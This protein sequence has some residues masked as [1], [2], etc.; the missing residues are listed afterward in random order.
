MECRRVMSLILSGLIVLGALGRPEIAAAYQ[1]NSGGGDPCSLKWFQPGSVEGPSWSAGTFERRATLHLSCC[2]ENLR[3]TADA[4][5]TP[6]GAPQGDLA[7]AQ[8]DSARASATLAQSAADAAKESAKAAQAGSKSPQADAASAKANKD[9]ATQAATDATT[10][11]TAADSVT[12]LRLPAMACINDDVLRL[13]AAHESQAE[14]QR[15]TFGAETWVSGA[16]AMALIVGGAKAAA[17]TTA[18]WSVVA[19]GPSV[20]EDIGAFGARSQLHYGAARAFGRLGEH[21]G[22]LDRHFT[23]LSKLLPQ[24]GL[25]SAA[26]AK[27]PDALPASADAAPSLLNADLKAVAAYCTDFTAALEQAQAFRD[28]MATARNDLPELYVEDAQSLEGI[29]HKLA[30]GMQAPPSQALQIVLSAPLD[31]LASAIRSGKTVSEYKAREATFDLEKDGLPLSSSW[32]AATP[33]SKSLPETAAVRFVGSSDT[34]SKLCPSTRTASKA[35]DAGAPA[36][37]VDCSKVQALN[38]WLDGVVTASQAALASNKKANAAVAAVHN[39]VGTYKMTFDFRADKRT[40]DI[41][42]TPASSKTAGGAAAGASTSGSASS[43]G[44][45]SGSSG[46]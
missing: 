33:P 7:Q 15:T 41:E 34:A 40:A 35:P 38:T 46:G 18:A 8:A 16:G 9:A 37:S 24:D 3:P 26:C 14:G 29:F 19:L 22:T 31:A 20:F 36:P 27:A 21:Y 28:A 10:A 45:S 30:F 43:T 25:L 39:D 42:F 32:A 1:L 6:S 44:A 11:Q 5:A 2:L 12:N 13:M 23:G 17:S 4:P